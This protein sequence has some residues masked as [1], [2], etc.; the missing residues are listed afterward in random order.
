MS[1]IVLMLRLEHRDCEELLVRLEEQLVSLKDGGTFD[2]DVANGILH[3]LS[4]HADQ[5]HHPKEALLFGRLRARSPQAAAGLANL[6]AEH[7]ELATSSR[8]MIGLVDETCFGSEQHQAELIAAGLDFLAAQRRH[9]ENEETRF[10]PTALEH[11]DTED[12]KDIEFA[13]FDSA[14]PLFSSEMDQRFRNLR[15]SI[16]EPPSDT[17]GSHPT[18]H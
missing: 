9:I 12:W 7:A 5:C 15:R 17:D 2:R 18:G 10:F 16:L 11:L 1:D 4:S 3:Y 13:V 6:V 8:V 14:K